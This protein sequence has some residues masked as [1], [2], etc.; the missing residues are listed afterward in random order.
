MTPLAQH[1]ALAVACST[2]TVLVEQLRQAADLLPVGPKRALVL[3]IKDDTAAAA[4]WLR[5][6]ADRTEK[7]S[8]VPPP[9][10][11]PG[12]LSALDAANRLYLQNHP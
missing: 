9:L 2:A 6:E 12:I 10:T 5:A 8:S 1:K 4:E 11:E 3:T 7:L